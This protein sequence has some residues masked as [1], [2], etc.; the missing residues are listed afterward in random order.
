[1]AQ[2]CR[3][4]PVPRGR[5]QLCEQPPVPLP[6]PENP[7]L[8]TD[9]SEIQTQGLGPFCTH[10]NTAQGLSIHAASGTG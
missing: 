7:T 9:W 3:T 10:P 8:P 4:D 2:H 6:S 1:M 5:D